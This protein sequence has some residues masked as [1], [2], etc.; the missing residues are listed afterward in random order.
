MNFT[1]LLGCFTPIFYFNCD[2][3]LFVWNVKQN[4]NKIRRFSKFS[5]IEFWYW[6]IFENSIIHNH[7]EVPQKIW[8]RSFHPFWR[9]LVKNKQTDNQ[10]D[11]QSK[12]V[13]R[14]YSIYIFFFRLRTI[15]RNWRCKVVNLCRIPGRGKNHHESPEPNDC[16]NLIK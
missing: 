11:T 3:F 15:W 1:R 7:H 6:Q 5:K 16:D 8:A 10:T 14:I 12:C 4:K 9:W 2:H 13:Y